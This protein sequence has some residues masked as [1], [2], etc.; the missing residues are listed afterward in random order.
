[1]NHAFFKALLFLSAGS[2]IH[3]L[4]NEQ[5]MRKM[6]GV[7]RLLPFTYSMM[8][9]GSLA[10]V[11]FPYLTGFYSKDRILEVAYAT[12]TVSGNFAY[13]FGTICV[14]LTSLY[15]FRLLFMTFLAPTTA[16][17][18]TLEHAHD[19]P[20]I[21]A[22]PLILLAFGSIFVGYTFSDMFVG[23]GTN[24]WGNA[25]FTLPKNSLLLESEYI[26]QSQK[27]IPLVF[28]AAGAMV[29]YGATFLWTPL[30][31][32]FKLTP[33]GRGFYTMSSRRWFFDQVYNEFFAQKALD[34][35]YH[36]SWKGLDKGW[37]E[38]LGPYGIID[39]FPKWSRRLGS[40]QSGLIP[41]YAVLMVLGVTLAIAC[42]ALW[43]VL[44][45]FVD[46]RLYLVF[47][48]TFLFTSTASTFSDA[49]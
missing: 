42:V 40:L 28:T 46:P 37:F 31:Y 44:E 19:A 8:V 2:V 9:I 3:G 14:F 25:V 36:V 35:G 1:M 16:T 7:V 32:K 11:G 22:L 39:T 33:L 34:F 49:D 47:F 38:I 18:H 21:M 23:L 10:L 15:S 26:P 20:P 17:A 48:L 30:I 13:W 29:A 45:G 41:H 24:F 27:M 5:D 6:G 12:Y 43:D 4:S